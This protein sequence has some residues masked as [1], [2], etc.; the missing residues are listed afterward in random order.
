MRN[1]ARIIDIIE[2]AQDDLTHLVGV[3]GGGLTFGAILGAAWWSIWAL[4][5]MLR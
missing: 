1:L 4:A 5:V 3:I 2:D